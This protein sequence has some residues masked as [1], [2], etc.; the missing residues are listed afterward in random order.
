MPH[1]I[2]VSRPHTALCC[3]DGRG[4]LHVW[5]TSLALLMV[6]AIGT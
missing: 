6:E 3:R 1:S 5:V 2:F 4:Q